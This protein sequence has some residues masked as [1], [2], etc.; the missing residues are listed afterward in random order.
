M[1]MGVRSDLGLDGA[2]DDL[3]A[4]FWVLEKLEGMDIY[5]ILDGA[6]GQTGEME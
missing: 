1:S 6:V 3:G 4:W 2:S 5:D